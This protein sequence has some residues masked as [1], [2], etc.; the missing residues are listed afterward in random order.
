M[1][2]RARARGGIEL[3]SGSRWYGTTGLLVRTR[4]E[5]SRLGERRGAPSPPPVEC[6]FALLCAAFPSLSSPS[7]EKHGRLPAFTR[8]TFSQLL[9]V[10]QWWWV[11]V[12]TQQQRC[13]GKETRPAFYSWGVGELFRL[14]FT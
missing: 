3:I 14:C 7:P 5:E 8:L 6:C 12:H 11:H 10:A 9:P 1:M 13:R 2:D 4:G